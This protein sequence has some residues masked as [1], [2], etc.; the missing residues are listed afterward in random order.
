MITQGRFLIL[1]LIILIGSSAHSQVQVNGY[2]NLVATHSDFNGL[3][4]GW[5]DNEVAYIG[6]SQVAVN[7]T[8]Q[9]DEQF[10]SVVQFLSSGR[11]NF[12]ASIRLAHLNW[13]PSDSFL[14]RIG[15]IR[16]PVFLHSDYQEVG[17]LY[18][19]SRLPTEIYYGNP[20]S[21][22]TGVSAN[23]YLNV[24]DESRIMLQIYGGGG[25]QELVEKSS[26]VPEDL[27][28]TMGNSVL[29]G[30][31]NNVLGL[32]AGYSSQNLNLRAS[33]AQGS[34]VASSRFTNDPNLSPNGQGG[35]TESSTLFGLELANLQFFNAAAKFDDS[36]FIFMAEFA[37]LIN[38]RG[39]EEEKIIEGAYLTAGYYASD[40]LI[41]ATAARAYHGELASLLGSQ[42][43]ASLGINYFYSS[44]LVFKI[45]YSNISTNSSVGS[46]YIKRQVLS[47]DR[48]VH[49]G[50]FSVNFSF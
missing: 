10:S 14:V 29:T 35:F 22:M 8:Y 48:T 15:K 34:F 16:L 25:R 42:D 7:L 30:D 3:Y 32:V 43:R 18:P 49:V 2:G 45:D 40:F 11:R 17:I 20:F 1:V 37:K 47:T 44:D 26:Q 50:D 38:I 13:K 12:D 6:A 19:W 46:Q 36:R 4:E 23:Y 27:P 39:G 24:S 21:T 33:L 9:I 5:Y 31:L 41:H 28:S